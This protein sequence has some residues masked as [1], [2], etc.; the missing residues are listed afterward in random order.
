MISKKKLENRYADRSVA[1]EIACT[2]SARQLRIIRETYQNDYKKTIEKD[3][4]VKVEGVVGKML[5]MLLCKSRNDDG[6]RVDDSLVEKHAQML[7]S[8]S[9]DEIG[10]NL[11]LFEQVFV[12][13]SWKHLAAVFDRVS[14][15]TIQT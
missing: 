14:S 7:L 1:I 12:G 8:N 4:A 13:N 9:L 5:T 15:Y 11:T 3:I 10:R 6:V 2:R